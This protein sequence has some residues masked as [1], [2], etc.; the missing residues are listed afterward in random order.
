MGKNPAVLLLVPYNQGGDAE[1]TDA[2][3]QA[4]KRGAPV[5]LAECSAPACRCRW[6]VC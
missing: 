1:Q 5:S 3:E 4:A 2:V 6:S